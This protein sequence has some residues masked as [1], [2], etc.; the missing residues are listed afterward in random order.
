MSLAN[1]F[2]DKAKKTLELR[3][4]SVKSGLTG[5]TPYV[6]SIIVHFSSGDKSSVSDSQTICLEVSMSACFTTELKLKEHW[7][8]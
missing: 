8:P 6:H 1:V 3:V 5:H 4:Y 7:R 2:A